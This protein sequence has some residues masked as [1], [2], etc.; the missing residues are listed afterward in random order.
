[1]KN[2]SILQIYRSRKWLI[3]ILFSMCFLGW[4]CKMNS[5]KK[6]DKYGVSK[7][8]IKTNFSKE[9][10]W[11]LRMAESVIKRNPE[12]WM[13]DF[14][15]T[16][17]WSY[18]HGLVL[19]AIMEVANANDIERYFE[20]AKS[21]AD[22]MI[23]PDGVIRNY[24]ITDYN[25]DHIN[26]GKLLFQL[27]EKT[28]DERYEKVIHTLHKQLKW[29]PRTKDGGYWHKLRYT[30][31]MWLDGLYMGEP[32][33]A[34]YA[35][36]YNQPE[37]FGDIANQFL[38][39][40]KHTRNPETGLLHHGWDESRNQKWS[41]PKTG[42]SP[43]IWGRAVGWYAMGLVD[44]LDF[45]PEEHEKRKEIIAILQRLAEAVAKVQDEKTGTWWQVMDKPDQE[46][47]YLESTVTCMLAYA[48][49]KGVNKGYL[50][51]KFSA[52]AQKAYNGIIENFVEVED[53]GEMHIHQCCAVA[54]LGGNPYR[55]GS[56]EY[57]VNEKIISNDTK[58]TGPFILASLEFEKASQVSKMN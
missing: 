24:K 54:G 15:K 49:I 25:I 48:L 31:Q 56:Y 57:Y 9:M 3:L 5:T 28:G 55:D 20:Y 32:F 35:M 44:V 1:M 14:R 36:K 52:I 47:N 38:L 7:K 17:R 4:N 37:A 46:G 12:S 51:K 22:T 39:M 43:E 33:Y 13:T 16:P 41:D 50:D 26:P 18:T 23:T 8:A 29:Q 2:Y 11:S 21:Y 40:E 42:K 19:M 6:Q 58:A 10:P 30:Y 27:H 53:D 45:F 34:C